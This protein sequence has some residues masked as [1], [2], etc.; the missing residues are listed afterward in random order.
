MSHLVAILATCASGVALLRLLGL[1]V[2]STVVD[3]PLGWMVGA[4][5]VALGA[6]SIRAFQGA[7]PGPVASVAILALPVLGWAVLRTRKGS[8]G[9]PAIQPSVPP[10][11][12]FPGPS[13]LF[14][15]MAAWT[16]LVAVVVVV[17]GV[18]T[19]THTDDGYRVRALA[20]LLVAGDAWSPEARE[21]IAM[22][23]AIPAFVPALPWT[24]GSTAE[25]LHVGLASIC[26]FLALLAVVIGL[27]TARGSPGAGWG[28]A[29]ALTSM[30]LLAYHATSTYSEVWL[31][32]YVGAAF[33]FVAAYGRWRDTGDAARAVLLLVGATMVKREGELVA[34]PIV[35]VLLFQ[36][37]WREGKGGLRSVARVAAPGAVVLVLFAA[38]VATVG[39]ANAFPFLGR[40]AARAGLVG[41]GAVA[42]GSPSGSGAGSGPGA[43]F[44]EALFV[45]G[46][47]GILYWVLLAS[48]VLLVPRVRGMGLASSGLALAIVLAETAASAVWLYPQYTLDHSTVHRSL[49]PVSAAAA[50]WLAALLADGPS[51]PAPPPPEE[52]RSVRRARRRA[53]ARA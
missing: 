49:I 30:P 4:A 41:T 21:V 25:P 47:F 31:A 1:A 29:F 36:V 27:G 52:A 6:F 2:G 42:A 17:H 35:V 14:G 20:P 46:N 22:A 53:G 28:G 32:A 8:G 51:V 38:R 9:P 12:R 34:L 26:A 37:A 43:I 45:D 15:P 33:A 13:W 40:I 11:R 3:V 19:P 24:L 39:A 23:G 48:L 5:W 7:G 10:R 18:S 50:V 44:L 16:I